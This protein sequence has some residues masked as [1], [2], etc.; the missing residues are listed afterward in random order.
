MIMEYCIIHAQSIGIICRS[1]AGSTT[2]G[3]PAPPVVFVPVCTIGA[4]DVDDATFIS[5]SE[6]GFAKADGRIK[7]A[8]QTAVPYYYWVLIGFAAD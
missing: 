8:G 4:A 7:L 3:T 6:P 5:S 2:L 1:I